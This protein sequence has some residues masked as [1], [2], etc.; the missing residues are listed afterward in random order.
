MTAT[1][2]AGWV[3]YACRTP[4]AVEVAEVIWRRGDEVTL[5][6]DNLAA[7]GEWP[8][9]DEAD[10]REAIGASVMRP[11]ELTPAQR[12]LAT[13][14]P[15]VTPGHR[16]AV[17]AEASA[18]GLTAFSPLVDPTSVVARTAMLDIGSVVNAA[19]IV[20]AATEVG[21][22]V[23]VNRSVS[24][25]HH[26]VVEDFATLGPGV[27]SPGRSGSAAAR[28]WVREP[29]A[30]PRSPSDRTPSWARVPL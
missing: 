11:D 24:I 27:C 1:V 10:P 9:E 3:I 5:L 12:G 13:V 22:F 29:S 30:L 26:G 23:Q 7:G 21:R 15:L 8:E 19:G 14:I 20:A 6:V 25:G 16:Y 2:V 17:A 28:S 18:L 4:Y